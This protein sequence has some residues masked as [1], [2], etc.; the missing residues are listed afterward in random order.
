MV[1]FL[2]AGIAKLTDLEEARNTVE[3]FGVPRGFAR[4]AGTALPFAEIATAIALLPQASARWGSVAALLLLAVF[5]AGTAIALSQ[6]RT[7]DCNCFGQVSSEQIS[8]RTIVRNGVIAVLAAVA[9]WKAPG[10]SPAAWTTNHSAAD[11]TA[12]AAVILVALLLVVVMRLR[13]RLAAAV[14]LQAAG[15]GTVDNVD[16][17]VGSR[18]PSFSLPN[19]AGDLVTLEDLLERA[20]PLVLVFGSP[21]CVPC[22]DMMPEVARWSTA[23]GERMTIAVVESGVQD[24]EHLQAQFAGAHDLTILAEP[25]SQVSDSYGV[26]GTPLGPRPGPGRD[27]DRT[28]SPRRSID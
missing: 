22:M 12:F 1:V 23:L 18:A 13:T 9:V 14:A 2:T 11:V 25:D 6:G 21:T 8:W 26:R 17:A 10:S 15:G 27:D 24:H 7:P 20:L 28:P 3:A 19:L 16:L 4:V 5:S